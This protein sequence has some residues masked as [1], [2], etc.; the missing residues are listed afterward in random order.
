MYMLQNIFILII[1]YDQQLGKY[2]NIIDTTQIIGYDFDSALDW[3][4]SDFSY[5]C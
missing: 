5:F 4:V 1:P 3:T 2:L